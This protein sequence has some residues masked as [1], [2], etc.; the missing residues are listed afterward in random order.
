MSELQPKAPDTFEGYTEDEK[1]LARLKQ[2][3]AADAKR[4]KRNKLIAS[5]AGGSALVAAIAGGA[6]VALGGGEKT[7]APKSPTETSAP[8]TPGEDPTTDPSAE[9]SAT[10]AAE[11]GI[12][13][14]NQ[15]LEHLN[16]L[17]SPEVE[18][19]AMQPVLEKDYKTPREA[20]NRLGLIWNARLLGGENKSSD[21]VVF[22]EETAES[23]V[24]RDKLDS[25]LFDP[26]GGPYD[27]SEENG[28][29]V[30]LY[31]TLD[32]I[33]VIF[34]DFEET[35][36]YNTLWEATG[37][38]TDLGNGRYEVGVTQTRTT[39]FGDADNTGMLSKKFQLDTGT[40]LS[41]GTAEVVLRDGQWFLSGWELQASD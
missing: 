21:G 19:E 11:Y 22:G 17:A 6:A 24:E 20:F 5:V 15:T 29:R 40:E 28:Q 36:T 41:E 7:P 27:L 9:T 8:V 34:S 14:P 18:A 3:E 16:V 38:V 30:L 2:L 26:E 4:K 25:V 12:G 39:N 31:M 35:A 10:P 32:G 13:I 1:Q 23:L 33:P 37:Q